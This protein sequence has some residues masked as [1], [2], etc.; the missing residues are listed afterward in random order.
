MKLFEDLTDDDTTDD[1]LKCT[2][3][4]KQKLSW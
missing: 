3:N 1:F 2:V 4:A